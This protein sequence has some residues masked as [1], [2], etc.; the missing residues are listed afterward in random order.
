MKGVRPRLEPALTF[1][2]PEVDPVAGAVLVLH[3]GQVRSRRAAKRSQLA[4][5]RM[6]PFERNLARAGRREGVA[7]VSML[8]RLRGWNGAEASPVA[9][10]F[11][12]L[13]QIRDRYGPIPVVLVGHS[14]GGRAALR[15]AGHPSVTGVVALAPWIPPDDPLPELRGKHLLIVHGSRDRWT[16]PRASREL[17]FRMQGIAAS[18]LFVEVKGEAHS[19]LR[20]APE[21][22]DLTTAFALNVLGRESTTAVHTNVMHRATGGQV[23]VVI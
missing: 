16:D 9:D 7:V 1:V 5:L 11:Y 12:G 20:R 13:D 2:D 14:M 6:R 18:A 15:A 4:V 21:W 10:V 17:V 22:H 3:G 8:F 19:M 23:H